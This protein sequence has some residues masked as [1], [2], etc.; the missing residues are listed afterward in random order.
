VTVDGRVTSLPVV[1]PRDGKA[2]VLL[3]VTPGLEEET[4]TVRGDRDQRLKLK[5]RL[6]V[7]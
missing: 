3:F 2:R 1:L 5:N 7:E 4:V 6:F